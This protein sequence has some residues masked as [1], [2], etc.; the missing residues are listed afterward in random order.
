MIIANFYLEQPVF[1][2]DTFQALDSLTV[3]QWIDSSVLDMY[4]IHLWQQSDEP[5]VIYV[6]LMLSRG[7][8]P[9]EE[10]VKLCEK[11]YGTQAKMPI[12]TIILHAQHYFVA[13]FDWDTNCVY[14]LGTA[15]RDWFQHS[16]YKYWD[17]ISQLFGWT[18]DSSFDG[19]TINIATW[20]QV[21]FL[22]HI[23]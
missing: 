1:W 8:E 4:V 20:I 18:V 22:I 11:V 19:K 6:G 7:E 13:V 9:S 21:C 12:A 16:G 14:L 10:E 2:S 15:D 17:R 23:V 3:S 5:P